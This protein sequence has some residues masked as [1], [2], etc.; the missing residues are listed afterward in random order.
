MDTFSFLTLSG[1]FAAHVTGNFVIL[2]ATLVLG[3]PTG[4]W[5]KV[6]AVPMFA[7]GVC[8]ASLLADALRRRHHT[9]WRPLLSAELALLIAALV[10]QLTLGPF[11]DA[12]RPSALLLATL[13]ILAMSTQSA[14]GLLAEP[15]EPPS[16]VMTTNVTR[17]FVNIAAL[18]A[19]NFQDTAEHAKTRDATFRLAEQCTAFLLGCAVSAGGHM[20]IGPW[21]L[22]IPA[23]V[24][25]V[26]LVSFN[27]P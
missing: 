9:V 15:K 7:V 11:P 16:V 4:V 22:A 10:I 1:L 27:A 2:A 25:A 14:T 19:S 3:H 12:D 18:F 5:S 13:L 23:A 21:F 26:L 17:L 20:F 24:I 8:C 6:F